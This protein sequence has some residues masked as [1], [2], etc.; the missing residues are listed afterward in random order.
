MLMT[1]HYHLLLETPEAN[2]CEGMKW[3]QGTYTQRFNSRHRYE[4]VME[5]R[6][7][8]DRGHRRSKEGQEEIKRLRRGWCVGGE[9]FRDRMLDKVEKLTGQGGRREVG[10]GARRD[11]GRRTVEGCIRE[12][13]A[14][15]GL[16]EEDLPVLRKGDVRKQS[17][18]CLV[19]ERSL[20]E[21]S[22]L[23][24]R[25]QMGHRV[26]VTRAKQ[27]LREGRDRELVR[28]KRRLERMLKC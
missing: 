10:R 20:V 26:N 16:T 2:L 14:A 11:H 17:I 25:L 24:E 12:S 28:C 13:L 6:A 1:N 23:S 15:L 22:W 5:Q 18:A 4:R 8:H 7:L 3:F 27:R 9:A 21:A 19:S